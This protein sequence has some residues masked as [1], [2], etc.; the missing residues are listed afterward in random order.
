MRVRDGGFTLIELLVVIIVIAILAAIAVP[1]FLAQ[2]E[3]AY[4]AQVQSALKNA[5]TA[6]EAYATDNNG[7]YSGLDTAPNLAATMAAN[8]FRVPAWAPSFDV[9]ASSTS[10]CIEIRHNSTSVGKPWRR[11][12]YFSSRGAPAADPNNCP[13]APSL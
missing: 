12:T 11:A 8:G 1:M 2:R 5:A 7:D 10:Y 6:V 13:G 4:A 3:K 9:V